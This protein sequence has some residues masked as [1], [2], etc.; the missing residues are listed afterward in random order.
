[1]D[2][3]FGKRVEGRDSVTLTAELDVEGFASNCARL[4]T[5]SERTTYK[6]HYPWI[7]RV[8]ELTDADEIEGL[9]LAAANA[10]GELR[11]TEFDLFP[12]ELVPE[13][14]V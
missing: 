2:A 8:E 1:L 14:I 10:L 6:R 5:E 13:E 9:E 3:T 11:F 7:D 12:P 4:L